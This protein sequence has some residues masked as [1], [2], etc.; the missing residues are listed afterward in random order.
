MNVSYGLHILNID[1]VVS[2]GPRECFDLRGPGGTFRG[3]NI[4]IYDIVNL[5]AIST[6]SKFATIFANTAKLQWQVQ[7]TRKIN[8][9]LNRISNFE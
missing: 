8:M 4:I 1:G 7:N 9:K 5:F 3:G 6:T 2:R